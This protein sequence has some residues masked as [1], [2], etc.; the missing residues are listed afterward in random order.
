VLDAIDTLIQ[1][2]AQKPKRLLVL[3][4]SMTDVWAD[5]TVDGCQ[6]GCPKFIARE[7]RE[8]PGGAANASRSL[9]NWSCNVWCPS[10]WVISGMRIEKRRFIADGRIVF[11]LDIETITPDTLIALRRL[12]LDDLY[13][14]A[15]DAVLI[16][17]Y[18]KGLLTEGFLREVIDHCNKKHIPCVV[19]GKQHPR[20]YRGA[21]L[22]CNEDYARKFAGELP[23]WRPRALV[24]TFGA[25]L[26]KAR[27]YP[28]QFPRDW[29]ELN[30]DGLIANHPVV[31]RNHV[32]AGDCFS[33]HLTLALAHGIDLR[34]AIAIAHSAGRVYVQHLHSR[35]PFAHEI[36]RDL[37]PVMGKV[38]HNAESLRASV[39][40]PLVFTNGVFRMFSPG[41]AWLLSWAKKHG[42]VLVVGV[43][44]DESA[45]NLRPGEFVLPLEER[46]RL[47][48]AHQDVDWV[49]PFGEPTP[50]ELMKRLR[51]DV[52]VKGPDYVKAGVVGNELCE[53]RIAPEG[54]YPDH[55]SNVVERIRA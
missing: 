13:K 2:D 50:A 26:P 17:D 44:D 12:S 29:S 24:G 37:D 33:A 25:N 27:D 32:G 39:S 34:D 5:G 30:L 43:N 3:G 42:A 45:A 19:D 18:D 8:T 35:P 21:I 52:V 11:R 15:I 20:L 48:A 55:V 53:V 51:P 22:K 7:Y 23:S 36:R 28:G 40:G 31:C 4:E 49:V 9:R 46:V 41:H 16:S 10:R 54:P 14:P 38:L 1:K 47:L 6:D